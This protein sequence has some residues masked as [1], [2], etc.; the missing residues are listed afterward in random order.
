MRI[1]CQWV[2]VS[3]LAH[4]MQH[5]DKPIFTGGNRL[6]GL[7]VFDSIYSPVSVMREIH[8]TVVHS[9]RGTAIFMH[10]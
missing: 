5:V 6:W 7:V 2:E 3:R 9:G 1:F 10:S 4:E 8:E